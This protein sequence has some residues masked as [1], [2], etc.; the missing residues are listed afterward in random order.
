MSSSLRSPWS[1]LVLALPVAAALLFHLGLAA[2]VVQGIQDRWWMVALLILGLV[3]TLAWSAVASALVV[4]P[5]TPWALGGAVAVTSLVIGLNPPTLL[6][7]LIEFIAIGAFA[8]NARFEALNRLRFSIWKTMSFGIS[9]SITLLLLAVAAFSYHGFTRPGADARLKRA[10]IDTAVTALNP[11]LPKV[12]PNYRPEA[13]IDELIRSTLPSGRS[14]LESAELN[15]GQL[16][17]QA[18]EQELQNRGIDPGSVDLN[19]FIA[20][21]RAS[22][23]ELARQIDSQVQRLSDELV[24]TTRT[25]LAKALGVELRGDE[26]GQDAIRAALTAR[27]DYALAPLA[28]FL[29]LI[30][31]GS[32]FLTLVI[33]TPLYMY[34]T[35]LLGAAL[36]W[37]L[38]AFQVVQPEE[39]QATVQTF[40]LR[41]QR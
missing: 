20:Q 35:W 10:L 18:I 34:L 16:S 15:A 12:L 23:D 38:R 6:A 26:R 29:P 22:Q 1:W 2:I 36:F 24:V 7:S 14:I 9:T 19:R 41:G 21:S 11:V 31:A 25:E 28:S 27:Y 5:W 40:R 37:I 39:H 3:I 4:D 17:R 30:L 13:T 32:L 8:R 33:F